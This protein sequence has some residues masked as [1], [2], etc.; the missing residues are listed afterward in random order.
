MVTLVQGTDS[1]AVA[2]RCG[3]G[4]AGPEVPHFAAQNP[5]SGAESP[6]GIGPDAVL[7]NHVAMPMIR[8]P[9]K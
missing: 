6:L 5:D 7:G 9:R 4:E 3:Y 2:A 1:A 8:P